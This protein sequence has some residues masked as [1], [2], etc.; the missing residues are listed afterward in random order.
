MDFCL[1]LVQRKK[2]LM[3]FNNLVFIVRRFIR[4]KF[5]TALHI[6]GLTL[7]ITVCLLIGLFY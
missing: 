5:T 2:L 4:Q 6:I 3:L 1:P 7:G